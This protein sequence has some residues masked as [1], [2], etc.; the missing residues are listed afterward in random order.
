[1]IAAAIAARSMSAQGMADEI[2]IVAYDPQ[3]PRLFEEERGRL[4]R[5]LPADRVLAIEHAGSTAIAGLAAKPIIDI[6]I[7]VPLIDVAR[8]TL[9]EPIVAL[10]YVYWEEN[11]DKDRM[12]FVKGMPPYGERRTHHVH[13]FEPTSEFWRR[14]LAFRDYLREHGDEAGRYLQ[15][16]RGLAVQYRSDRE[17]YSRAKD[18]Y[19]KAVVQKAGDRKQDGDV[20]GSPPS[21]G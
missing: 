17:A 20:H 8:T 1:M 6:F 11:P 15:L 10:G 12:F 14:A 19:V 9:V 13:I 21:R 7:A 16:K 4:A 2:E 5:V 18:A 3:W